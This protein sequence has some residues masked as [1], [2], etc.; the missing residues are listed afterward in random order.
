MCE[1]CETCDGEGACA[2]P[3]QFL[4]LSCPSFLSF[5]SQV[6]LQLD[7]PGTVWC[8]ATEVLSGTVNCQDSELQEN[9]PLAACYFQDRW[10]NFDEFWEQA[11]C[12][13]VGSVP[14]S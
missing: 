8:A 1:M 6:R 10:V 7:E 14:N 13:Y 9:N 3:S 11:I 2:H 12:Y 5:F 4:V